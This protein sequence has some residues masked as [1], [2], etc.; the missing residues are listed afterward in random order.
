M[1][2]H[3][4]D[5]C[6]HPALHRCAPVLYVY[7]VGFETQRSQRALRK[8]PDV[9]IFSVFLSGLRALCVSKISWSRVE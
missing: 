2:S 8:M 6:D 4:S 7:R 1:K 9:I 3:G 5:F